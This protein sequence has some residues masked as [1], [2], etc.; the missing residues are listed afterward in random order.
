MSDERCDG[1]KFFMPTEAFD[2]RM[3][4]RKEA[5]IKIGICRRMPPIPEHGGEV[6]SMWAKTMASFWCGEFMA[7]EATQ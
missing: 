7:K 6:S 3:R 5:D 1:C 2:M 4:G